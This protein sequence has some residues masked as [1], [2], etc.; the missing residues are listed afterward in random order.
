MNEVK[1]Y[2]NNNNNINNNITNNN[3]N[4]NNK[5]IVVH[6]KTG[7]RGRLAASILSRHGIRPIITLNDNI[8][9]LQ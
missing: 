4:I 5:Q 7:N 8:I 2:V 6:C 1:E 3:N 9:K